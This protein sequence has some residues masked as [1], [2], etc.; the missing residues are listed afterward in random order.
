MANYIDS[1]LMK[2]ET[3]LFQT[4][5]HWI[6]FLRP[7]L[8]L[9]L[10]IFLF[11]FGPNI[12]ALNYPINPTLPTYALVA[13]ATL[14]L[15]II[16]AITAYI[17]YQTSEYGITTK[18]VLMKVGF[19]RRISLEIYFQKIESVKVHQTVLGRICGYGSIIISGVGGS[20]DPFNNIPEP[21][22]FRSKVQEQVEK[23]TENGNTLNK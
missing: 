21:L 2:N 12:A 19:I 17:N 15:T 11:I 22:F 1:T 4:K 7:A 14:L 5:P 9:L 23:M 10:T 3:V 18:R 8:L 20:K 13:C 16:F 6:I